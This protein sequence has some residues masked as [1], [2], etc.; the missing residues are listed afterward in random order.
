MRQQLK[1]VKL[2]VVVGLGF[3]GKPESKFHDMPIP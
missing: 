3:A 2:L 1:Q